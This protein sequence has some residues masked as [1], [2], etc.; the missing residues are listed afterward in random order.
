[1]GIPNSL[2][3]SFSTVLGAHPLSF[4]QPLVHQGLGS[5]SGSFFSGGE[6][7]SRASSSSLSRL[8][9]LAACCDEGLRVVEANHRPFHSEPLSPQVFVQDGDSPVCA[10]VG[11][12]QRLDG[13]VGCIIASSN[14]SGQ[15]QVSQ[16]CSLRMGV[17]VQD[18]VLWS[19]HGSTGFHEGHGS[20]INLS[21]SCGDLDSLLPRRLADPGSL[22]FSG[23]LSSRHSSAVVSG[24]GVCG[25]LGE[26]KSSSIP[27]GRLLGVVLDSMSFGASPSQPR[28]EKLLLI[29][30]E[31][32][33]SAV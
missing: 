29:G 13:L 1:M 5:G 12:K 18:S 21:S 3:L 10:S 20:G 7:S 15:P 8:L 22:S 30:E 23:S 32:L 9:Q 33:S 24:L 28:V 2:P 4:V 14:P 19:L 31:F 11:A 6:R 26:V 16:V 25:E 27:V 17:A